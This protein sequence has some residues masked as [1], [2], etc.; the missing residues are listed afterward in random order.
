MVLGTQGEGSHKAPGVA[1][2]LPHRCKRVAAV[3]NF[4][5]ED[6]VLGGKGGHSGIRSSTF[7]YKRQSIHVP[8]A[9]PP[10]VELLRYNKSGY[11]DVVHIVSSFDMVSHIETR[12]H[13]RH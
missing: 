3:S 8:W 7:G 2:G 5:M 10:E 4:H 13:R 6:T 11:I 9:Y 1:L 12:V